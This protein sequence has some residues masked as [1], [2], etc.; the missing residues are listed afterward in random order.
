MPFV[1]AGAAISA[2]TLQQALPLVTAPANAQAGV[3]VVK[4]PFNFVV[5]GKALPVGDYLLITGLH[6]VKVEDALGKTVAIELPNDVIGRSA[7]KNGQIAFHRYREL[8][9][10]LKS[11]PRPRRARAGC[12]SR[13]PKLNWHEKKRLS[14]SRFRE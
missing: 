9:F 7:G 2:F 8:C 3:A 14:I 13:D 1:A 5:S 12:S 11:A 6:Q 4:I 10:S